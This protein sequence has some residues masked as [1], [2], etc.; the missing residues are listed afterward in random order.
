MVSVEQKRVFFEGKWQGEG[1]VLSNGLV[2]KE[3]T[4]FKVLRTEP[5]TILNVQ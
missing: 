2:Y 4:E 3:S 1:A 5:V